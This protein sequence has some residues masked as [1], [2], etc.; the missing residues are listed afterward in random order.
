MELPFS[1]TKK[2]GLKDRFLFNGT[3]VDEYLDAQS[4]RDMYFRLSGQSYKVGQSS[5]K[6]FSRKD[7]LIEECQRLIR[8]YLEDPAIWSTVLTEEATKDKT[9]E[10]RR[11]A[12]E[13]A[14][15]RKAARLAAIHARIE[16]RAAALIAM[17]DLDFEIEQKAME[18]ALTLHSRS[19]VTT[20]AS[21]EDDDPE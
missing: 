15:I 21:E 18:R 7:A 17:S 2:T 20:S 3:A 10:A 8:L 12:R 13:K 4:L 1:I 6:A 16:E 9:R 11:I 5:C 19:T 14:S